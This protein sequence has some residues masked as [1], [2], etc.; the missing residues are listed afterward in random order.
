MPFGLGVG[1]LLLIF[2]VL[3]LVFGAK[4]LPELGGALGK[5]IR[6]FKSSLREIEGELTRP[7][8]PVRELRPPTSTPQS[9]ASAAPADGDAQKPQ[10]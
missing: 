9:T 3:L 10:G 8:D 5:G 1:E 2:A 6:E 4:R 7:V